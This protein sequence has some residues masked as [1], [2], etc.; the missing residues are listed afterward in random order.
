[1]VS[2]AELIFLFSIP[3]VLYHL[4]RD[5][6]EIFS[7]IIENKGRHFYIPSIK[8]GG[9]IPVRILFN[10]KLCDCHLDWLFKNE[11]TWKM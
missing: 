5:Y 10:N 2:G 3:F 8:N 9:Y 4:V 1:L 11:I 7:D 6:N